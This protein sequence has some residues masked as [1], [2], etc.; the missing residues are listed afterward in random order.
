MLD[1]TKDVRLA[2][3]VIRFLKGVDYYIYLFYLY[4]FNAIL[5]F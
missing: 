3:R 1:S 2:S 5:I 4:L